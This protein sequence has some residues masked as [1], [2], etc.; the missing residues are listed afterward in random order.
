[1]D[2]SVGDVVK[3]KKSHP[4]GGD[5]WEIL[6]V[7]VDFK[8]RCVKCGRLVMLPRAKFEKAVK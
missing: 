3:T 2:Y 5:E 1:M 4:C 6:R 7:G 8:M